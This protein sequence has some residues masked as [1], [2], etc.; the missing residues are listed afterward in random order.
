[1]D[2]KFDGSVGSR[3]AMALTYD[4]WGTTDFAVKGR[5][6]RLGWRGRGSAPSPPS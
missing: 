2:G 3:N 6:D 4:K 5:T 1:M